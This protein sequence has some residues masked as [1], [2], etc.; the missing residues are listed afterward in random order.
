VHIQKKPQTEAE[1][2]AAR[3]QRDKEITAKSNERRRKRKEKEA[4]LAEI[5]GVAAV[6]A[7]ATKKVKVPKEE[8]KGF[9]ERLLGPPAD[10]VRSEEYRKWRKLY[11]V[12]L[13]AGIVCI[14]FSVI[15]QTIFASV[16]I[17]WMVA[18]AG[19]Y[20]AIIASF[21]VDFK[22]VRPLTKR[23]AK[24]VSTK[25]TPKMIRHEEEAKAQ[26]AAVEAARKAAKEAKRSHRKKTDTVVPGDKQ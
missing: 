20:V 17:V 3:K 9:L 4:A 2:R 10:I 18:L 19:A 11:W 26:A 5:E 21:V 16:P 22:K 25:K 1:K 6:E 13:L 14:G 24:G 7:V 23:N 12:L 15:A 8:K